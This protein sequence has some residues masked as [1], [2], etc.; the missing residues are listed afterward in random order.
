VQYV[1]AEGEGYFKIRGTFFR[2]CLVEKI[3]KPDPNC[4]FAWVSKAEAIKRLRRRSD[5]W[6]IEQ[7]APLT[8]A[9]N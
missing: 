7:I 3:G 2:A 5:A 1:F 9:S 8:D 4:E 6:A